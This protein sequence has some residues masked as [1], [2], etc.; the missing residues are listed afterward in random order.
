MK[1]IL[2]KSRVRRWLSVAGLAAIMAWQ[3]P[4]FAFGSILSAFNSAYPGSSTGAN[5]SCQT[6]HGSATSTWNEYGWG[7]RSNGQ[8]FAALENI[9]S[10]NVNGG[11]TMLD[12]I[13]ASTQPGWTT[14]ANN[15]LYNSGGLT[16]STATAPDGIMVCWIRRPATS[17]R[18]RMPTVPTAARRRHPHHLRRQRLPVIP[19]AP[20][21]PMTGTSVTA[22][23]PV[24]DRTRPTLTRPPAPTRFP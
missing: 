13:N 23:A 1:I 7:L 2:A 10:I 11:T 15:N 19:T 17:R 6:C 14:G 9:P 8:N 22:S 21:S 12:E 20:S 24:P 5:A 3:S 16:S 4:V 18:P